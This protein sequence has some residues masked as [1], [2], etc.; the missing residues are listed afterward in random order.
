MGQDPLDIPSFGQVDKNS[1]IK[2]LIDLG[3]VFEGKKDWLSNEPTYDYP[4]VVKADTF[5]FSIDFN[6]DIY[7]FGKQTSFELSFYENNSKELKNMVYEAYS[8]WYGTPDTIE[9]Y[10][11][12]LNRKTSSFLWKNQRLNIQYKTESVGEN[13]LVH[14]IFYKSSNFEPY[15]KFLKDSIESNINIEELVIVNNPRPR[16]RKRGDGIYEFMYDINPARGQPCDYRIISAIRFKLVIE[17]E[18][19]EPLY[20]SDN[21]T[22]TL[23]FP[24]KPGKDCSMAG[25]DDVF[26]EYD[27]RN[28]KTFNV[29]YNKNSLESFLLEKARKYSLNNDI[30]PSVW[31]QSVAFTDGSVLNR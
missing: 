7:G 2:E 18:F 27:I 8:S 30:V 15:N 21:Q 12:E 20:L 5:N 28:G 17:D 16:W 29:L 23:D 22:I 9:Q 14:Q 31:I 24:L 13:N 19:K 10:N 1:F 6:Q 25:K 11:A 4:F 26:F 3:L